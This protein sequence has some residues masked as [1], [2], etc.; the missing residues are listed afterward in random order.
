MPRA[1]RI[2]SAIFVNVVVGIPLVMLARAETAPVDTCLASPKNETPA[3]SH[4]YY[5]IDHASKRNCWYLRQEGG[6]VAQAMPQASAPAPAP[7]PAP[8]PTAKP[9]FSDAHAELRPQATVREDSTV[10][11]PPASAP[12]SNANAAST[13]ATG[14]AAASVWNS[15]NATAAVATR[16]PELPPATSVPKAVAATTADATNNAA[17]PAAAVTAAASSTASVAD[18][19]APIEP[20]M[21]QTLIAAAIGALAFAGIAAIVSRRYRRRVRRRKATSAQGPIWDT[22]DDDRI[23][24]SDYPANDDRDYRPRFARGVASAPPR[25]RAAEFSQRAPEFA[26]RAPRRARR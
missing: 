4:W 3:G 10:T 9:S 13:T 24:L 22:T 19:P 25:P 15:P 26:Q 6:G 17:L 12:G 23:V 2:A 21:I 5:R 1:A 18:L 16:W 14:S 11:N 20:E 7:A 8:Q